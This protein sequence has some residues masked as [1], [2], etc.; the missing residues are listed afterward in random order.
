MNTKQLHTL[1]RVDITGPKCN[2][3]NST[4]IYKPHNASHYNS[5]NVYECLCIKRKRKHKEHSIHVR[6]F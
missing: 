1:G 2:V 3:K 6:K 4:E 5:I